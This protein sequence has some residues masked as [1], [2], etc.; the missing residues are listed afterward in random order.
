MPNVERFCH[1]ARRTTALLAMS[2]C[3]RTVRKTTQ[4]HGK[5]FRQAVRSSFRGSL[6]LKRANVVLT[7]ALF[8]FCKLLYMVIPLTHHISASKQGRCG[9]SACHIAPSLRKGR[10]LGVWSPLAKNAELRLS[11]IGVLKG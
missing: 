11:D 9:K 10:G 6:I 4:Q 8:P 3:W 2:A 7:F 5:R 1:D